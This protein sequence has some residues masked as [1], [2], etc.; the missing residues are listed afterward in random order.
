MQHT[1]LPMVWHYSIDQQVAAI[2]NKTQQYAVFKKKRKKRK[3]I[4][5][6]QVNVD[7]KKQGFLNKKTALQTRKEVHSRHLLDLK[8]VLVS[9]AEYARCN[10]N[11]SEKGNNAVIQYC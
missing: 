6:R 1:F 8:D 9:N 5:C 7:V 10:F 11:F 4:D 2:H 3:E